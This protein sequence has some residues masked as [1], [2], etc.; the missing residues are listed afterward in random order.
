M[1]KKIDL[2]G[3]KFGHLTVLRDTGIRKNRQV[4]WECEC[5]CPE[6][7]HVNV[8]GQALRTLHTTSCGCAKKGKN[9]KDIT[10]QTFGKLTVLKLDYIDNNRK[11][12]WICQCQCGSIE[13]ENGYELRKG[14]VTE[15]KVCRKQTQKSKRLLGLY[16]TFLPNATNSPTYDKINNH[17]FGLLT[18]LYPLEERNS[19]GKIQW[20]C[21]CDCGNE[22]IV[23]GNSLLSGNTQSCGCLR[24][25]SIGEINIEKILKQYNLK[26][27]RQYS[28]PDLRSPKNGVLKFDF[29]LLDENNKVN[30]L[31]EFDGIQHSKPIKYWNGENGFQYLQQCDNLKNQYAKMHQIPL[32]RLPYTIRDSLT[33]SDLLGNKYEI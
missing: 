23:T 21:R 14:I 27:Y 32:V 8:V 30:R 20:K 9:I 26:F 7:N 29:A 11:A 19:S 2:T 25:D 22:T 18:P 1:G 17:K 28:F 13:S 24:R 33:I 16:N 3:Q 4:V 15:C 31:I 5:D 12:H 6:H 10:G